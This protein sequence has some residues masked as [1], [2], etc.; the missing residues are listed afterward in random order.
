MNDR[1]AFEK[2][3]NESQYSMA[4]PI[5]IN[6][7][8]KAWQ[9]AKADNRPPTGYAP[10]ENQC[11]AIAARKMI[12]QLKAESEKLRAIIDGSGFKERNLKI[13][14]MREETG[15]TFKVIGEAFGI[16][17]GRA[18][19]IFNKYERMKRLTDIDQLQS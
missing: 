15:A 9:A 18:R 17:D 12:K 5:T 13:A 10:C 7:L 11:E 3:L 2:W 14:K 19:E 8:F 4:A 16:S 1:E 6:G